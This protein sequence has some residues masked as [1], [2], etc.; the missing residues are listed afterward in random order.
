MIPFLP[1]ARMFRAFGI[2]TL[3]L[4]VF[5]LMVHSHA[6]AEEEESKGFQDSH[7]GEEGFHQDFCTACI[8]AGNGAEDPAQLPLDSP[9]LAK[10]APL[11]PPCEELRLS[12][13]PGLPA[14]P[15]APPL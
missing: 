14:P 6:H 2:L 3:T 15:R 10:G 4:S 9:Y 8:I 7:H 13:G 12:R 5:I 11:A 1:K